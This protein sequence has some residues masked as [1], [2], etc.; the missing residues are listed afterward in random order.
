MTPALMARGWP[1]GTHNTG[2]VDRPTL[3]KQTV[4]NMI[5]SIF[6]NCQW[7]QKHNEAQLNKKRPLILGFT[8]SFNILMPHLLPLLN[9]FN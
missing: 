1:G 4:L 6:I 3:Q 7:L 8:C 2:A 9:V 5:T